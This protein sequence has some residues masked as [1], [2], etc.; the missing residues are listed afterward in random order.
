[1]TGGLPNLHQ[2][3]EAHG[4][5]SQTPLFIYLFLTN[6]FLLIVAVESGEVDLREESRAAQRTAE[7]RQSKAEGRQC[8]NDNWKENA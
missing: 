7:A 5:A 3:K 2:R 8:G 1:M 6:Q 4:E